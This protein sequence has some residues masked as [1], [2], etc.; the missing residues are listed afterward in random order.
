M[1]SRNLFVRDAVN[2]NRV[3]ELL[4]EL[5]QKKEN[6]IAACK[7]QES[8]PN[9]SAFDIEEFVAWRNM[10]IGIYNEFCTSFSAWINAVRYPDDCSIAEIVIPKDSVSQASRQSVRSSTSSVRVRLL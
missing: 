2:T 5:W 10:H 1:K 9:A 6:F 7:V 4:N 3:T 8:L